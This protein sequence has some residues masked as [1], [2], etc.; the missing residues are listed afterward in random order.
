[1]GGFSRRNL[2]R[3]VQQYQHFGERRTVTTLSAQLSWSHFVEIIRI[4]DDLKRTFYTDM[5]TQSRWSVRT[6]RERMDGMLFER[7]SI[8]KQPEQVIR[9]R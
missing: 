3:M 7:R 6:L 1:M 2:F 4:D 8:A 5:C 9:S